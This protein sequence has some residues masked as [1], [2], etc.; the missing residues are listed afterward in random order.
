[1]NLP[2]FVAKRYLFAKKSHNVINII[3]LISA[4]GIAIGTTALVV[5][6]SVYNGFEGLVKG[7][8]S[9]YE[10]DLVIEPARGKFFT[11]EGEGFDAV[12]G[13]P[14]VESVSE[15]LEEN[16]FLTYA[17]RQSVAVLK[18]VDSVYLSKPHLDESVVEGEFALKVK[19]VD[20]AVVGRG[21]ARELG[22]RP[23]FLDALEVYYPRKDVDDVLLMMNPMASLSR[24][25]LFPSG[26]V[27]GDQN[28][29]KSHLFVSIEKARSLLDCSGE[30]S[31]LEII[32]REGE[33]V[34]AVQAKFEETL[35]EGYMVKNRYQQN[36]TIYKMMTYEKVAIYM[37][38]LF[39]IIVVSCNVF[40]SLTMLIIEKTDD[41]HTLESMGAS[42]KLIRN[43]F[44]LEGWLITFL[45]MICGVVLGVI[46]C[47]IQQYFGVIKMPGSFIVNSYPVVVNWIDIVITVVGV[48]LV[49]FIITA[50]P[51]WRVLP[52]LLAKK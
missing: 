6:L 11:P 24:E 38:L 25:I 8:Y 17:G 21:L 44:A 3:S 39:I 29:E 26:V 45:G 48:S 31:S 19:G 36:E 35:G 15:V 13:D 40:G 4:V 12:W 10:A 52:K 34:D 5:V 9:T 14:R 50:L 41:I 37:I 49:G 20:H 16:V 1:M 23:H 47:W 33:D 7:I 22:L 43:I 30:V 28:V 27:K 18:G 51:A 2:L 32:I 46:L 42:H